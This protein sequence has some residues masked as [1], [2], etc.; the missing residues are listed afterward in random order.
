MDQ[1]ETNLL[2]LL[3]KQLQT[4]LEVNWALIQH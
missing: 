4:E 3:V 1:I 2:N